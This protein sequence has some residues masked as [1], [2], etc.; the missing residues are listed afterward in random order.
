MN[1]GT[2]PDTERQAVKDA[3]RVARARATAARWR[4]TATAEE[5][6]ELDRINRDHGFVL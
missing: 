1:G 2:D 3:A 4:D 6:A 5:L